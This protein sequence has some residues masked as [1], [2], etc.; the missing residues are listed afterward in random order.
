MRHHNLGYPILPPN[1]IA[2]PASNFSSRCQVF[3][4]VTIWRYRIETHMHRS[5]KQEWFEPTANKKT[6][7]RY[8]AHQ[9]YIICIW[10]KSLIIP[11]DTNIH[12]SDIHICFNLIKFGQHTID[13][14]MLEGKICRL[15]PKSSIEQ[16][17]SISDRW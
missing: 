8:L 3:L 1:M 17:C 16:R 10:I 2:R 6:R 7:A 11:V 4:E 12:H 14:S 15:C 9:I 5:W 13:T